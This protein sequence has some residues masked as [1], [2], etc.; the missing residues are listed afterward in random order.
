MKA[1]VRLEIL[2][3]LVLMCAAFPAQAQELGPGFTKVKDGIYVYAAKEGNSTCSVVVTEEGPVIIDTCQ[4]PPDTHRLMAGVKKLTDKPVRF[5]IDTE[6]HND[7]TFGHWVFS[8]PAMV[9]NAEG[10]GAAMK[11]QFDPKR[12][13]KLAAESPEMAEAIKGYKMI[14]PQ[15]EYRNQMTINLGERTF[16]LIYLK[17][18][19]SE[20][21]TAVWLPKERVLFAASAANV[22]SIINLRP[23]VR[24]PDV[25]ASYK[26]MKSLNPEIVV[27]GHGAVSTTKIFDEYEGFYNLL[28]KRVGEMVAQGKSPDEIK[29]ELKMPEYA[30]W[31]DQNNLPQNITVAYESLKK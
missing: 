5:V 11:K 9:I 13:E 8:P 6:I 22:K 14:V 1:T 17:N 24:I 23:F 31:A 3:L 15:I 30:D 20:A 26:L 29:K 25:L 19:H 28:M 27:P 16:E 21:D 2:G 18:V 4:R 10:A 7:H 12:V